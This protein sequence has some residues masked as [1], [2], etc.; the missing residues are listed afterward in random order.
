MDLERRPA[1]HQGLRP[2][3]TRA[4]ANAHQ[5]TDVY[6]DGDAHNPAHRTYPLAESDRERARADSESD[7]DFITRTIG[8]VPVYGTGIGLS[9][10][11]RRRNRERFGPDAAEDRYRPGS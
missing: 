3:D 9:A 7:A 10:E 6:P 1:R 5:R 2:V 4:H 11:A 8:H